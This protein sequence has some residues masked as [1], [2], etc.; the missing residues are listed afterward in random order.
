[1]KHSIFFILIFILFF[2][3]AQSQSFHA[4]II[5][6]PTVTDIAGADLT[7]NDNDFHKLGF[8]LGGLVNHKIGKS[9]IIQMELAYI[10]KG[11]SQPYDSGYVPYKINL[12]YIDISLLLK[13]AIHINVNKKT[14]G[15]FGVEIGLTT[16]SLISSGFKDSTNMKGPINVNK[17]DLELLAGIYYNF[18]PGFYLSL[19]YSNSIIHAIPHQSNFENFYPYFTMQKGNNL[20]FQM[21]LGFVF[22][23]KK[24]K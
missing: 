6:G 4:G 3:K 16:G 9:S 19:R 5:A 7:D 15:K 1:M 23:G 14:M 13:Q 21:T 2:F 11:S 18:T 12:N 22:N 20:V 8:S 17:L 24:D 10:Q